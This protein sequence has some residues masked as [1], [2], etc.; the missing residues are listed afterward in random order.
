MNE[1]VLISIIAAAAATI[2]VAAIKLFGNDDSDSAAS[3]F[4]R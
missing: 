4:S 1:K 2:T 3:V